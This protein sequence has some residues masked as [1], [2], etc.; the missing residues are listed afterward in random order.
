MRPKVAITLLVTAL[1]AF[2]FGQDRVFLTFPADG[3]REVWIGT[4]LPS[5]PPRD[6]I[7]SG[8][9]QVEI[10]VAGK[11]A[12]DAVFVWDK[13]TGN[14]ASKSL[15]EVKKEGTWQVTS[16]SYIDIALVK[17]RVESGGKPVAAAEVRLKD[18]RREIPQLLDPA[19]NG[20][21]SFFAVK[22]GSLKVTVKYRSAGAMAP[23]VTQLLDAPL[24]RGETVPTLTIALPAGATTT[25]AA[26][27][28]AAGGTEPKATGEGDAKPSTGSAEVPDAGASGK[29]STTPTREVEQANPLGSL[30]VMLLTLGAVGAAVYFALKYAKN[31]QDLV[32]GKLEQL[33]VQVP[34]P[35]DDQPL[36]PATTP[37]PM[38]AK[39]APPQKIMLDG[40]APDPIAV[41]PAST[42]LSE[43]RLVAETG[44]AMPLPEG[45][46]VVGREVGLGL[47]LVGE[48]TVS[49]RH[50]QLVRTGGMVIVK[51]LG[52]T[53]GTFV[54]GAQ[55]QGDT[56]L[57][58]GDAVQFGSVRFRYEG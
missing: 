28:P 34:K 33:G 42:G 50:A 10:P 58:S 9:T 3:E 45:E 20:E 27:T 21:I 32:S 15:G 54:N 53:N 43:P 13:G 37:A 12:S 51:D 26:T 41:T 1:A 16:A 24:K 55:V 39:P 49:R 29:P 5:E 56:P 36:D 6:S 14:L 19:M 17:V 48:T 40:A 44:D 18:A 52:S 2:G 22:P 31:N 8:R 46:T 30:V 4:G 57:R 7:R 11:S 47:S 35:G 25:D 23:P 38:P